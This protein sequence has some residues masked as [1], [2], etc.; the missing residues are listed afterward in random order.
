M[1]LITRLRD[2]L[3][4]ERGFSVLLAL[5][6]LMITTLLLGA[7]YVAL[8]NDVQLGRNDLDQQ[9]A[10][11]AAKAGVSQ[12][13][14][15]LN[16]NPNYWTT[17][18]GYPT[19]VSGTV[20]NSTDDGSTET[21]TY[22]PIIATT[23]P[24]NDQHCDTAAAA[25]TMLEGNGSNAPGTFRVSFTGHS[26]NVA[27]T[28]VAQFKPPSFL[29]YVYYTDYETL[30]PAALYNPN[31]NPSEPTDCAVHY[32]GRGNDC[33]GAINFIPND[34]INGPLHSEDTLAV[35]GTSNTG[36]T[37]GRS[38]YNDADRGGGSSAPRADAAARCTT[39]STTPTRRSTPPPPRS[40]RRRAT[41]SCSTSRRP[42][43]TSTRAARRS[44]STARR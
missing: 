36:P 34:V 42:T 41:R 1:S 17:C 21:Y 38:G 8:T 12:Y 27:R 40:R 15:Q 33:G 4:D 30:D 9:R 35:C 24:S 23:A 16:Q 44:C 28:I 25:S 18:G 6:V 2:R 11:A 32:P 7:T 10:Y 37:F 20:P 31:T 14:Y 19:P 26:N 29:D 22:K 5:F 43:A 13:V 39:R 3:S